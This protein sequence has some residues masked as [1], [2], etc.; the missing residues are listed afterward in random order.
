M[1]QNQINTFSNILL[2]AEGTGQL[3]NKSKFNSICIDGYI[4]QGVHS[5]GINIP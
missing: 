4:F 2:S 1:Y 3:P 5:V